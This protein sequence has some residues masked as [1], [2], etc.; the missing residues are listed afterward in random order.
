M[1]ADGRMVQRDAQRSWSS[2]FCAG[3]L[4]GKPEKT[5]EALTAVESQKVS[6]TDVTLEQKGAIGGVLYLCSSVIRMEKN[7]LVFFPK[8]PAG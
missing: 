6:S 2:W 1:M 3:R 4:P 5:K 8:A 7:C